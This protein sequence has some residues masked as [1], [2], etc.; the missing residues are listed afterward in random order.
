MTIV[1]Q[2]S[3][4]IERGTFPEFERLSREGIWPYMEARGC[5]ILGLFQN[6]HGGPS[7]EVVLLTAYD[8]LAHWESTRLTVAPPASS[9]P[10]IVELARIAAAA[11]QERNRLTR[12][13]STRV[14]RLATPWVDYG[15]RPL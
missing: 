8:S 4:A 2:R 9:S 6:L 13:S 11:G 1:V 12:V 7:D 5:K 15:V 10:E 3:F 14:L